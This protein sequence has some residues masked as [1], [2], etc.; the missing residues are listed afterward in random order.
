MRLYNNSTAILAVQS[1]SYVVSE[2]YVDIPNSLISSYAI[3]F[4][5]LRY[6]LA[7]LLNCCHGGLFG[8]NKLDI[9]L[10]VLVSRCFY[11]WTEPGQLFY[12][13]LTVSWFQLYFQTYGEWYQS[14]HRTLSKQ[15]VSAKMWKI[16]LFLDRNSLTF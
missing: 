14:S 12:A 1:I 5:A 7:S 16:K 6:P 11:I 3:T 13:R 2:E 15:C 4:L 9:T 10:E 8:L